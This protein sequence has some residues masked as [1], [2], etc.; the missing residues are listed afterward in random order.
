VEV[1]GTQGKH[2]K[3]KGG[4]AG[5]GGDISWDTGAAGSSSAKEGE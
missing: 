1:E 4:A 3:R 2:K 5:S